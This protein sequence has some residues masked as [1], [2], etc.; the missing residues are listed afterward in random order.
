MK[1]SK[2]I[3]LIAIIG[4]EKYFGAKIS[5]S[6]LLQKFQNKINAKVNSSAFI[7]LNI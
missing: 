7:R 1:Q 2:N 4:N 5:T 6:K 3:E